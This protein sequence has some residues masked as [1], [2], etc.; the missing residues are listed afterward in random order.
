MVA[1]V[2]VVWIDKLHELWLQT[3]GTRHLKSRVTAC[4]R[5]S[6]L[7][8]L[9]VVLL[10]KAVTGLKTT[11]KAADVHEFLLVE[12]LDNAFQNPLVE[13]FD[14]ERSI[15]ARLHLLVRHWA[16]AEEAELFL[17]L[18]VIFGYFLLAEADQTYVG[19]IFASLDELA[20]LR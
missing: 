13:L 2:G 1:V 6:R 12:H 3:V 8:Y 20:D 10:N 19:L 14:V 7:Q 11:R 4:A 17:R 9:I 5:Y 18:V 15:S 16:L